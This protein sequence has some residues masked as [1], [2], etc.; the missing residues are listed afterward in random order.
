[1]FTGRKLLIATKHAKESV[2]QP[3]FEKEF[4]VTCHTNTTFDTDILGTFSGEIERRF[5]TME[6]LRKKCLL[7]AQEEKFDLIVASEGSFGTHPTLFFAAADDKFML[8]L[9]LKNNIEISSREISLETNFSGEEVNTSNQLLVFAEKALFPSHALILKSSE[10][11][12]EIIYKGI[13]QKEDLLNKFQ[14]LKSKFSS[15]FVETD[16][17][18]HLNPTRMQVIQKATEKL[19]A[20]IKKTCPSCNF[21]GFDVEEI[22]KGLPCDNCGLPTKSTLALKYS[23]KNCDFKQEQKFPNNKK[24][25]EPTF[26]DYCNP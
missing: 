14:E 1:M 19:V 2:I 21:P 20:K 7:A 10:K 22:I 16:M 17:R 23:C 6:T 5:S 4:N 9:D 26:C 15:V 24:F 8:F 13:V 11:N 18:A 3:L 12:P 25:E